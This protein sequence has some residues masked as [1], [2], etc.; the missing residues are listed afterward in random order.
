M[1]HTQQSANAYSPVT[2]NGQAGRDSGHACNA[3]GKD[4]GPGYGHSSAQVAL[5]S[6]LQAVATGILGGVSPIKLTDSIHAGNSLLGNRN[7][8]K[9]VEPL[10]AGTQA[11]ADAAQGRY[12]PA[13]PVAAAPLTCRG[14]LQMMG[15]KK[16]KPGAGPVE[17]KPKEGKKPEVE[18]E[19]DKKPGAGSGEA[20]PKE[21][22][23]PE[24]GAALPGLVET[25]SIA[26]QQQ[27]GAPVERKKK[28]SRVQVALNTLRSEGAEAFGGYIEA[29]IGEPALLRTLVERINRAEDLVGVQA[30]ALARVEA[31]L[32]LLDPGAASAQARSTAGEQ[33]PEIAVVAPLKIEYSP[34]EMELREACQK[35][36]AARFRRFL[37]HGNVDVNVGS[38]NGTMLCYAAYLGHR[39]IAAELISMPGIDVN[40]AHPSGATPLYVA[41]ENGHVEMV[42]LLLD[43]RGIKINAPTSEGAT[44]LLTATQH[45]HEE[46]VKLLLDAPG[47]KFDK[48][49]RG[50]I[51]PISA[52]ASFNFTRIVELLVRRGAD[53]NLAEPKSPTPLCN[54]AKHGNLEMARILL[55]APGV[56]VDRVRN[57]PHCPLIVASKYGHKNIVKELI[58]HGADVKIAHG[59]TGVTALHCACDAGHLEIAKMLI[60]AGADAD[61]REK[62]D[63]REGVTPRELVEARGDHALARELPPQGGSAASP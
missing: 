48:I 42:R 16:K 27:A 35:G 28:K 58:R 30:E 55:Q 3:A 56:I 46:V 60:R 25:L 26:P 61:V 41:A 38:Q 59:E 13:R 37:R 44:P 40:L 6:H 63:G 52:A 49:R 15:K 10:V 53:V 36:D 32:R 21:K 51:T 57:N 22:K 29:E 4:R 54:A 62:L 11:G 31:R 23:K 24:S 12:G 47:I 19:G 50:V 33:E 1:S 9:W 39:A 34:R 45:G 14:P 8:M 7:F 17:A 5:A 20:K 2:V 43:A 18:P